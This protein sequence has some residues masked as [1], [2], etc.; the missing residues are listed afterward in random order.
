MH[1]YPMYQAFLATQVDGYE[2]KA[3]PFRAEMSV[4]WELS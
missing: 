4:G 3:G 2:Q 1:S